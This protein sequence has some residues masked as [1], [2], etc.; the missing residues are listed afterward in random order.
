MTFPVIIVCEYR[1]REIKAI[2][3]AIKNLRYFILITYLLRQNQKN[4]SSFAKI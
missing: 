4:K 3:I 2:D 1:F